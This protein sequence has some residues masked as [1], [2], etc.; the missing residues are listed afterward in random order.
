MDVKPFEVENARGQMMRGE[1][2]ALDPNAA[3]PAVIVG[4]GFGEHRAWGYLPALAER[5]AAEGLTTV[6]FDFGTTKDLG[7]GLLD[8]DL[9]SQTTASGW[10]D[11]LGRVITGVFERTL[12][13]PR[14]F[15]IRRIGY[16]GRGL[17]GTVG[18]L[19][20]PTDSRLSALV[21]HAAPARWES[22]L[23]PAERGA[24]RER[25]TIDV[26]GPDHP[27]T[28]ALGYEFERDLDREGDAL[29]PRRA[30]IALERPF[31]LVHGEADE[32]IPIADARALFFRNSEHAWLTPV[33]GAGH[34]L[35]ADGGE[36][37]AIKPTVAFVRKHLLG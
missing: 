15:D 25:G 24:W 11:D 29:D 13:L 14:A 28:Y 32:R 23:G 16:V 9:L 3:A 12:P 18:L 22:F 36:S 19:R 35:A 7:G 1:V 5:I 34:D 10:L 30:A 8:P 6:T 20:A 37:P 33:E 4:H 31:C 17:G 27:S 2:R 26:P 21:L